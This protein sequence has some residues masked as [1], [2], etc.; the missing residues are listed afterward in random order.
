MLA[1]NVPVIVLFAVTSAPV[2][3]FVVPVTYPDQPVKLYPTFAVAVA[4]T[5]SPCFTVKL[6]FALAPAATDALFPVCD[7]VSAF[8]LPFVGFVT[9][10]V[11]VFLVNHI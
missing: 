5:L 1:A 8:I 10:T 6:P 11:Y 9:V 2:T 7:T 3:G 4:L